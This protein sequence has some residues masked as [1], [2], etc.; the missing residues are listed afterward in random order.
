MQPPPIPPRKPRYDRDR[1]RNGA[2][3][4][5]GYGKYAPFKQFQ[6]QLDIHDDM[7]VEKPSSA[8]TANK[9]QEKKKTFPTPPQLPPVPQK[10]TKLGSNERA[11]LPL[12]PPK[13]LPSKQFSPKGSRKKMLF[14]KSMTARELRDK[15]ANK[16]R[17]TSS[18]LKEGTKHRFATHSDL[19][20]QKTA[21]N[22][23]ELDAAP[24]LPKLEKSKSPKM[25]TPAHQKA[26]IGTIASLAIILIIIAAGAIFYFG[27]HDQTLSFFSKITGKDFLKLEQ[28]TVKG[29]SAIEI[30]QSSTPSEGSKVVQGQEII[31][32]T[33]IAN[34]SDSTVSGLEFQNIRPENTEELLVLKQPRE[35]KN[36]ST[37]DR[38][39]IT[40]I[41]IN[42][43]SSEEITFS[44]IVCSNAK[45]G[46]Q[47]SNKGVI[48]KDRKEKESNNGAPIALIV[49]Q[50]S[51]LVRTKE[52]ENK[53]TGVK[54]R[55]IVAKP[56][57]E[58]IYKLNVQ[59]N[60]AEAKTEFIKDDIKGIL[61]FADVSNASISNDD[62]KIFFASLSTA[63]TAS[64]EA[65]EVSG[66]AE[67]PAGKSATLTFDATVKPRN[68]WKTTG[69][70]ILSNTFGSETS[71][72]LVSLNLAVKNQDSNKE[73]ENI[74]ATEGD[75]LEFKVAVENLSPENISE[76]KITD[77]ISDI[78]RY[79][80][81][82]NIK[83]ENNEGTTFDATNNSGILSSNV[84]LP[85]KGNAVLSFEASIKDEIEWQGNDRAIDSVFG[86]TVKVTLERK[87]T[88]VAEEDSAKDSSK[89][90]SPEE[91]KDKELSPEEKKDRELTPEE[92]EKATAEIKTGANTL[93]VLSV[94]YG[95]LSITAISLIKVRKTIRVKK[96]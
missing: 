16:G 60:G 64:L 34:N 46:V 15:L 8:D 87:E 74:S 38:I 75:T 6:E 27:F 2:R 79:S 72:K 33:L 5:K 86:N 11:T 12:F 52:V 76:F 20:A 45:P 67:I 29:I 63:S 3:F 14:S 90:I 89:E 77:D 32:S 66:E 92:K 95:L 85:A 43:N 88:K 49:E 44:A 26:K 68:Q 69:D 37:S 36:N 9:K 50:K 55:S 54:G 13:Q 30:S 57:D 4:A 24:E 39:F 93:P 17:K 21:V 56:G 62:G 51:D 41:E 91:Q 78:E 73:G 81:I 23:P 96:Q 71:V 28:K 31:F 94:I 59:N 48:I 40:D 80:L 53:T 18:F 10:P 83:V 25:L 65:S 58:L 47:I 19:P 7:E 35:S 61:Y 42:P 22:L 70:Y 1:Q 84:S 82:K